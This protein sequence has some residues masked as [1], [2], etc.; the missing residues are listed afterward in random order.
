MA[1]PEVVDQA[2]GR[3]GLAGVEQQE[4]DERPLL[5]AEQDGAVFGNDFQ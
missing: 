2:V 5:R 1:A 3:Q 4:C